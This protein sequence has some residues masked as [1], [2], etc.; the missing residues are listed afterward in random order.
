MHY[1]ILWNHN[2]VLVVQNYIW[3]Q[4]KIIFDLLQNLTTF[5][6][7]IYEIYC[8]ITSFSSKILFNLLKNS[9]ILCIYTLKKD[10]KCYRINE[11]IESFN[12]FKLKSY[13]EEESLS[14]SKIH[15]TSTWI[16]KNIYIKIFLQL[17]I[18]LKL[19]KIV[20]LPLLAVNKLLNKTILQ[21]NIHLKIYNIHHKYYIIVCQMFNG[22][23]VVKTWK[24]S[25][26]QEKN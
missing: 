15:R 11:T 9:F 7:K 21:L 14:F 1:V 3:I 26:L 13:Y 2:L 18:H 6:S 8:K 23:K 10:D 25:N 16:V 17:N 5:I 20:I 4:I 24:S 12:S 19:Y 22:L